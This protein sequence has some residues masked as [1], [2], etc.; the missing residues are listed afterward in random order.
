MGNLTTPVVFS[1][2]IRPEIAE[3]VFT[4]ISKVKPSTLYLISDGARN[5]SEE[6]LVLEN[7][8]KIESMVN[9]EC[10][11]IKIFFDTN[12]G[13]D[14][15][16]RYSFSKIFET[17]DKIIFLEEDVLPSISFFYF[18]QDLLRKYE[19]DYRVY[20]VSGMNRLQKY[21]SNSEQ[22]YF[23]VE[24][25]NYQG[26]AFWKRTFLNFHYSLDL[27]HNPYY[28]GIVKTRLKAKSNLNSYYKSKFLMKNPNSDILIGELFFGGLNDNVLFNSL[29]IVP[30][31][32]LIEP[33]GDTQRSENSDELKVL[34]KRLRVW[35]KMQSHDLEFP[36][37]HPSFMLNDTLYIKKVKKLFSFSYLSKAQV[38]IE[39]GLRILY[40]RGFI[41]FY[42]KFYNFVR[43]L[44][45]ELFLFKKN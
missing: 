4:L 8:L 19:F 23:F 28:D 22:S 33:I 5:L 20:L 30:S 16:L 25:C 37:K 42:R 32:N 35:S 13:I 7:R 17:E 15:I 6:H 27:F 41:T 10:N 38:K 39:R 34:P 44:Y 26:I 31:K 3:K 14:K 11:L 24:D 21:P 45:H 9:W 18:C 40:F 1:I 43:R 29:A 2:F 12:Q 36:L